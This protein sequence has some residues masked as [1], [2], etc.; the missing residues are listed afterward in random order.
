MPPAGGGAAAGAPGPRP[1]AT[2]A[3][4][5]TCARQC[6]SEKRGWAGH[7]RQGRPQRAAAAAA[8]ASAAAAAASAAVDKTRKGHWRCCQAERVAAAAVTWAAVTGRPGD[9]TWRLPHLHHMVTPF[10]YYALVGQ[11]A[12]ARGWGRPVRRGAA[13]GLAPH[14]AGRWSGAAVGSWGE[15][16][17]APSPPWPQSPFAAV[18]PEPLCRR[19]P[20]RTCPVNGDTGGWSARQGV[21]PSS[22]AGAVGCSLGRPLSSA[23]PPSLCD[24]SARCPQWWCR[25]GPHGGAALENQRGARV[26]QAPLPSRPLAPGPATSPLAGEMRP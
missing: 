1:I 12:L 20:C 26:E 14:L 5:V 17:A 11:C 19:R 10:A 6:D 25:R 24:Q 15:H 3:F 4:I 22:R 8:A 21:I 18:A 9:S 16:G 2:H 7:W 13:T 23:P